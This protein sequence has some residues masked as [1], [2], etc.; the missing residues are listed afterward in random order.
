M[1]PSTELPDALGYAQVAAALHV[2]STP[3]ERESITPR[4]VLERFAEG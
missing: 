2:S 3:E 4:K 1:S